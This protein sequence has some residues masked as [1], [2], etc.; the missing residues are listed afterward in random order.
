MDEPFAAVDAQTR[1]ILQ[2]E[3]E[4][5]WLQ[6]RKTVVF[7][8]HSIDEAIYL[9]VRVA[10][11]TARPGT[12]KAIVPIDLPRPRDAISDEFN[13]Y[14]REITQLIEFESR[15]VFSIATAAPASI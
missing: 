14:R 15:K 11:M 4:R 7:V 10:V 12:V 6:T 9:S 8:T 2:E 3:L 1:T 5:L 13:R